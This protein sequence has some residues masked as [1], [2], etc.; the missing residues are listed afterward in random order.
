MPGHVAFS[1]RRSNRVDDWLVLQRRISYCG[2]IQVER[3]QTTLHHDFPRYVAVSKRISEH[4]RNFSWYLLY[5]IIYIFDVFDKFKFAVKYYTQVFQD[6]HMH[7]I[8][9]QLLPTSLEKFYGYTYYWRMELKFIYWYVLLGVL[10]IKSISLPSPL[11]NTNFD[12]EMVSFNWQKFSVI[13]FHCAG[14]MLR[15]ERKGTTR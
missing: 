10:Q 4:Q 13:I 5:F 2:G 6:G 7:K 1:L 9:R 3:L 14:P 11:D 15:Y 8:L 12:A